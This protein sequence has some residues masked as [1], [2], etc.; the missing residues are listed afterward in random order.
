MNAL[1]IGAN[2]DSIESMRIARK[3]GY[4]IYAIDGNKDAKGL[5][6]ADFSYVVDINNLDKVFEITDKIK[7]DIVLPAPIGHC[8][9]TVGAVN[10]R[11]NLPGVG[12]KSAKLCTD[13][14]LFNEVLE[15]SS[16][17]DA[18]TFLIN[19]GD[20]VKEAVESID[21]L[22]V[23]VKPRTGSGSRGI[24]IMSSKKDLREW[25]EN[26][27]VADEDYTVERFV[28][29]DEYGIDGAFADGKFYLV[30]LR[31]KI[32]T[33]PPYRQCVGY[34]SVKPEE[35]Q[36]FYDKCV[37]LMSEIG[38]SLGFIN[39]V[40]H[41]DVIKSEGD[42]PFVIE[43]SARPS[44]HNLSNF[45]TPKTTGIFLVEEFIKSSMGRPFSYVPTHTEKMMIRFFDLQEGIVEKIPEKEDMERINGILDY[46][47]N[48]KVG[49]S[50]KTVTDGA[51]VMG[52][53][54]YLIK[55]DT[56]QELLDIASEVRNK[57]I[58]NSR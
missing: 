44:G 35:E 28:S 34:I 12:E 50:L 20:N 16:L 10:D 51:S 47:C 40:V 2:E 9:T 27:D 48:I 23:I 3:Y 26:Y 43:T 24:K 56:E 5:E 15:K 18:S 54:Y 52:R 1:V 17:R 39:C 7:A 22:P 38:K 37:T 21:V 4:T 11:Y 19:K 32:N 36:G 29:G 33:P 46:N 14:Y 25:A 8:L 53:G 31:K 6:A 55:A 45:F 49:D 58:I 13:K 42:T 30:L 41:V 57:F